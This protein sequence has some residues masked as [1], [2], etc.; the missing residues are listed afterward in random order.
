MTV[1]LSI[2]TASTPAGAVEWAVEEGRLTFR[3]P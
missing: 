1:T 3:T 2:L